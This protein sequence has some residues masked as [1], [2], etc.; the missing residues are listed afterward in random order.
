ME[1]ENSFKTSLEL[2]E[3]LEELKEYEAE[4]MHHINDDYYLKV[5]SEQ[6]K[7]VLLVYE[8]QETLE[9]EFQNFEK[10]IARKWNKFPDIDAKAM[11]N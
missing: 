1:Q 7:K 2:E 6:F 5:N 10:G 11:Y 3:E 8:I 4:S 9:T